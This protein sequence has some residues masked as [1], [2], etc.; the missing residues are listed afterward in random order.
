MILRPAL[1][2]SPPIWLSASVVSPFDGPFECWFSDLET[3]AEQPENNNAKKTEIPRFALISTSSR[4]FRFL[5]DQKSGSLCRN[6]FQYQI[7]I[8]SLLLQSFFANLQKNGTNSKTPVGS[9]FIRFRYGYAQYIFPFCSS[10]IITRF[11]NSIA[12]SSPSLGVMRP[13]SCSMDIT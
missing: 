3:D 1:L 13:S 4:S 11:R 8:F 5:P 12:F 6:P 7:T 2:L 10:K 9:V